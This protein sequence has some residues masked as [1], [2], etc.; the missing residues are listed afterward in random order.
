M[1]PEKITGIINKIPFLMF[2]L[3]YL[4]NLGYD[5]YTFVNDDSSAAGMKRAELLAIN[6]SNA[7]LQVKVS[8]LEHFVKT[9]EEKKV[10]IRPLVEEFQL[11][12]GS[13]S[14]QLDTPRF[15]KM[16]ITEAKKVGL[17]VESLQ[18][19]G[20]VE[21]D[22]YLESS[23]TF[24]YKGVFGQLLVFLQRLASATEIIRIDDIDI[25]PASLATGKFV[26]IQG[27][28]EIRTYTYLS[29][30]A[31]AMVK[32]LTTVQEKASLPA[33]Q[34]SVEGALSSPVGAK[35]RP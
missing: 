25:K 26:E 21:K 1:D 22:V 16:I 17:K 12:S 31:D 10:E 4:A 20:G 6:N 23:F 14:E 7:K 3:L 24:N 34:T 32:H 35:A 5:Y 18:P 8:E 9:L 2:L 15:M 29:A 13:L 30:K 28:I 27:S 11:V 19:K 33:V